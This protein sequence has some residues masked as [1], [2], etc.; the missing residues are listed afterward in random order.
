MLE[1]KKYEEYKLR[2]SLSTSLDSA[3]GCCWLGSQD[4]SK[5]SW[6]DLTALSL[7]SPMGTEQPLTQGF[8]NSTDVPIETFQY[9]V[10]YSLYMI[11]DKDSLWDSDLATGKQ[12]SLEHEPITISV[13]PCTHPLLTRTSTGDA[14]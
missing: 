9:S 7:L 4:I 10:L 1:R 13:S 6:R 11:R 3:L 12:T 14:I 8:T 5:N 2:S